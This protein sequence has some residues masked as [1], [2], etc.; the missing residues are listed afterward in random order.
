LAAADRRTGMWM[1]M[2]DTAH[3]DSRMAEGACKLAPYSLML[4]RFGRERRLG[5]R[6][7]AGDVELAGVEAQLVEAASG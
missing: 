3:K 6:P 4:L 2:V 1:V 5:I 7:A